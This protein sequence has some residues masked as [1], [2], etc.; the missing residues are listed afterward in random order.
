[1]PNLNRIFLMG[2]LTRDPSLNSSKSGTVYCR[3][4][5]AINRRYNA[6]DG[7]QREEVEMLYLRM[8]LL[9]VS[10]KAMLRLHRD[11]RIGMVSSLR[12]VFSRLPHLSLKKCI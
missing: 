7:S 5:L 9:Q 11:I 12:T 1:M 2:R 4:S 3:F 8:Y 6:Q 10:T